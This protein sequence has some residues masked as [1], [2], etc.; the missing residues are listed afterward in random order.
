MCFKGQYQVFQEKKGR[1]IQYL[2]GF[3]EICLPVVKHLL[4]K[5][6]IFTRAFK[7]RSMQKFY[8][9]I[10]LIAILFVTASTTS[11][12][13]RKTG[14]PASEAA[15]VQPNRKGK[16]PSNKGSSNLFPKK[17][18]KTLHQGN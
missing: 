7:A 3:W 17:V 5:E 14:C 4:Q 6:L 10:S 13:S 12:C 11:S 2:Q 15:H 16:Y 9:Y 1:R 18:R 8:L